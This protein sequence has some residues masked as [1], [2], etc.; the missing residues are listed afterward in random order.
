[1]NRI[2]ILATAGLVASCASIVSES[3]YPVQIVSTPQGAYF[4]VTDRSGS[5]VRNGTTPQVIHLNASSGFFKGETYKILL[6]KDGFE[7]KEYTLSSSVD[8]WYWGNLLIGGL[9]GM[10]IVDPVTGAMYKLPEQAGGS[11]TDV[12]ASDP[13]EGPNIMFAS[14]GSLPESDQARL[15]EIL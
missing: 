2:L 1:M 13:A 9:I 10:L 12:A 4:T 8:G 5:E 14:V 11:L 7:D 3:V 15:E 6:S